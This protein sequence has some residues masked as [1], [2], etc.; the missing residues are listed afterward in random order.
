MLQWIKNFP[1]SLIYL[2]FSVALALLYAIFSASYLALLGF[3]F[4]ASLSFFPFPCK[5]AGKFYVI[6]GIFA[7]WFL[8]K[9]WQQ[10]QA[11]QYPEDSVFEE[12]RILPGH[13]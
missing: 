12:V 11:G 3:V 2:E 6:C 4:S 7:F 8:F 9:N 10:S 13:N 1:H 5:P